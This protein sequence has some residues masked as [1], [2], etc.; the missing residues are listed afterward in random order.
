MPKKRTPIIKV[1][2]ISKK[3]NEYGVVVNALDKV[4]LKIYS[5]EF[6]SIIGP[7][8]SGKSTLLHCM[9]LLD[10]P[11]S[12]SVFIDGKNTS[13]ISGKEI[14]SFRGEKLGFVFQNYN[15]IPRLTVL[16][17]VILPGLIMQKEQEKL[18]KKAKVLLKE[19][20]IGHRINHKGI[21]LSGGEQQRVAI[22]RA[23]INNPS[24]VL[25]DEP[26]GALDTE[27]SEEI[28]D[29]LVEMNKTRNVTSVFVSHDIHIASYGKRTIV[30]KDGKIVGDTNGKS[31]GFK[32]VLK[33]LGKHV[34]GGDVRGS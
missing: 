15:L 27:S 11:S 19:V 26:T 1:D 14:A 31:S 22:A 21:H 13:K 5:G 23:L 6:V 28:M 4:S 29:L 2:T 20:G 9:G 32:K 30:I 17:N 34:S 25:A 12:G 24:L 16:E 18:E 10:R 8:G 33:H 7:S 3:Y